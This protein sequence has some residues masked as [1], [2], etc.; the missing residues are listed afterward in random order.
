MLRLRIMK[1]KAILLCLLLACSSTIFAQDTKF[2]LGIRF[3]PNIAFNRV[4]DADDNDGIDFE[5]N[6][7]GVR[8]S[9][10]VYGDFYFGKN[11][12]FHTG[13]WYSVMRSGLKYSSEN[14]QFGNG[15]ALFNT[16]QL[17]IPVAL[18]LFTNDIATD[19]KLYFT[20]GGTLGLKINEKRLEWESRDFTP[21]VEEPG[22]IVGD[23]IGYFNRPANGKA[24]LF[25]D[26]GLLLG[27]GAE[28]QMAESTTLF[29]GIVY[30]RGLLDAA[31]KDGLFTGQGDAS[32]YYVLNNQYLGLEVGIKF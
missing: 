4:Q 26:V 29:G 23:N 13:L 1:N 21:S 12:A 16:Q 32:D 7:A 17:Q 24:F 28:Y 27:M 14:N 10:G 15:N 3:A 6:G 2:K 20:L 11:Y 19:T 22:Y 8:F 5:S 31:T 30:N 18:K 9:A 25:G